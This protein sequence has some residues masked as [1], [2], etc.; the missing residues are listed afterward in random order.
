MTRPYS[1]KSGKVET[2]RPLLVL[3]HVATRTGCCHRRLVT[4]N[5]HMLLEL[6]VHGYNKIIKFNF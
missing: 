4:V 5:V 2:G 6:T 3:H 1:L